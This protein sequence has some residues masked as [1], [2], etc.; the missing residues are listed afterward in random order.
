MD[1]Q[2]DT[3]ARAA[4]VSAAIRLG[5][6]VVICLAFLGVAQSFTSGK[7]PNATSPT[8]TASTTPTRAAVVYADVALRPVLAQ[9]D[10]KATYTYGT[11]ADLSAKL[12]GGAV[13]DVYLSA[14]R[15]TLT[16]LTR[17]GRCGTPV[18]FATKPLYASCVLS[19]SGADATVAAA[20]VD[21]LTSLRG[22]E[23]LLDAGIDIPA[24]R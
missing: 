3:E 4:R 1:F 10:P 14:S 2:T 17:A 15:P 13:A 7:N 5:G 19:G 9:L 24:E 6:F 20:F 16:A 18:A 8:T 12:S 11:P 23:L 22:R 21:E